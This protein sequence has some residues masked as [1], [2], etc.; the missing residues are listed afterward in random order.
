MRASAPADVSETG[1]EAKQPQMTHT[2]HIPITQRTHASQASSTL[3]HPLRRS[4]GLSLGL[5][6]RPWH[7]RKGYGKVKR[8][9]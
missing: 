9:Q 5:L 7:H 3:L 6:H 4:R 8:L 2:S 1:L